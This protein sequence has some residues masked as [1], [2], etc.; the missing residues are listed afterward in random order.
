[1]DGGLAVVD[2][3][4]G[5]NSHDDVLIDVLEPRIEFSGNWNRG[6][7]WLANMTH[8]PGWGTKKLLARYPGKSFHDCFHT[9][10]GKGA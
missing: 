6:V 9:K 2:L 1:M 8:L 3:A 4:C 10:I 5:I 7:E